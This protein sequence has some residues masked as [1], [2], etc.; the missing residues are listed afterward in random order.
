MVVSSESI[1]EAEVEEEIKARA[2]NEHAA[3]SQRDLQVKDEE[4]FRAQL[5]RR[6]RLLNPGFQSRVLEIV[7]QHKL[8]DS[9][10]EQEG[11]GTSSKT[12]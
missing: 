5:L 6:S 3:V 9:V 12:V 1:A 8:E 11:A 4:V 10:I 2:T 7:C